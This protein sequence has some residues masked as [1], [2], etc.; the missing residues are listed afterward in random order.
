MQVPP[1]S[2]MPT[3]PPDAPAPPPSLDPDRE[4]GPFRRCIVSRE[5]LP[6]EAM[7]RFVLG[8]D[9]RVVPDVAAR[10]PGRGMWLKAERAALDQAMKKGAFAR[11]A[12]ASVVVPP[13][14]PAEIATLL[15][16]R[17]A[18]T[19]GMARRAGQSVAGF[20]KVREWLQQGR[21]GVLLEA[22]DGSPAERARLIGHHAA[23]VI[24]ALDTTLLGQVFGRDGAVHVAVARG[25]LAE[26]IRQESARLAGL[27]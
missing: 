10:L 13:E 3:S 1:R 27:T 11:A 20:Q 24:L 17:L 8:P 18:D 23:P 19:L 26:R 2:R 5:T 25:A 7:L 22:T 16:A 15:R 14:L 12:K 4:R 6:K 9:A 21:V